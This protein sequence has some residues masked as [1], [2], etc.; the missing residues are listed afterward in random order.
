[1]DIKCGVHLKNNLLSYVSDRV[2]SRQATVWSGPDHGLFWRPFKKTGPYN[3][4][5]L[6]CSSVPKILDQTVQSGIFMN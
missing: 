1:V 2:G 5:S 6:D 3:P 4:A